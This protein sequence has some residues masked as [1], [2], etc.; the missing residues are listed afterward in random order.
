MA[1]ERK[2]HGVLHQSQPYFTGLMPDATERADTALYRLLQRL[3][4]GVMRAEKADIMV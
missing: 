1:S 4:S 2:G 3:I